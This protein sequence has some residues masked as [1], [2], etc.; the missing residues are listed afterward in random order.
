MAYYLR[1]LGTQPTSPTLERLSRDLQ[2]ATLTT[3]AGEPGAWSELLLLA[4]DGHEIAVIERHEVK[5]GSLAAAELDEFREALVDTQ[6]ASGAAWITAFLGRVRVIHAI[7]VLGRSDA[8]WDA[9]GA[10]KN[11]LW[12]LAGDAIIQADGE[13]FTN[14]AGYQVVWQF[15]DKAK[16]TWWM[17]VLQDDR[18]VHFEMDLGDRGQRE[19]FLRGE[20]PAGVRLAD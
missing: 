16:G 6:P 2:D 10:V 15:S 14:T 3:Q 18:W 1:V 8:D 4:K 12:N 5:P 19:A 9:I 11:T 7:H 20:V 17:G 13:G